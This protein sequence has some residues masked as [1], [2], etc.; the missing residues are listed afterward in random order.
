MGSGISSSLIQLAIRQVHQ[1]LK[2]LR[3]P[4]SSPVNQLIIL[5][6]SPSLGSV[7]GQ[8]SLFSPR[9]SAITL[10]SRDSVIHHHSFS[11]LG[12]GA[13]LSRLTQL[14][15]FTQLHSQRQL[16]RISTLWQSI[17]S[18]QVTRAILPWFGPPSIRVTT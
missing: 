14:H 9:I 17:H 11:G 4:L 6:D 7:F 1:A 13:S 2:V 12:F 16:S 18:S 3:A 8:R 5:S 15:Q 10:H